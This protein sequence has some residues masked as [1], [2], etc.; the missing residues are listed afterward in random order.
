MEELGEVRKSQSE[1]II[2]RKKILDEVV[3]L[4]G[5]LAQKET[6]AVRQTKDFEKLKGKLNEESEGRTGKERELRG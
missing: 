2:E 1:F 6:E 4:E 3:R 5:V